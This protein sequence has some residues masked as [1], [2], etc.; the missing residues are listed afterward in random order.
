MGVPCSSVNT[1]PVKPAVT[2]PQSEGGVPGKGVI[3]QQVTIPRTK[4]N[5]PIRQNN[6]YHPENNH[7]V[8]RGVQVL[9]F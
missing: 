9:C 4:K 2:V 1:G 7:V 8:Q 6:R 5:P 3:V